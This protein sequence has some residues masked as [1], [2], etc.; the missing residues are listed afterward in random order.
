MILKPEWYDEYIGVPDAY[1]NY[2]QKMWYV[3]ERRLTEIEEA[4]F[5]RALVYIRSDSGNLESF[6]LE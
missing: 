4:I 1:K 5:E 6:V 3:E 2:V